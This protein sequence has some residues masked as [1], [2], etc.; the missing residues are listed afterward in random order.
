MKPELYQRVALA[1]DL[2]EHGLQKGDVAVIV[3]HLPATP[4]S[5]GEEGYA[6]EVF[7]ALGETIAVVMVPA[8][9]VEPLKEDEILHVRPLMRLS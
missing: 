9:A 2:P 7:N 4:E 3:E 6:L 5:R 1:R 8:S